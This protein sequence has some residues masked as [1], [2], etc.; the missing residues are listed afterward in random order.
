MGVC[1]CGVPPMRLGVDPL[2]DL[3]TLMLRVQSLVKEQ[4]ACP[5]PRPCH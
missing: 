2:V 1:D 5:P 4:A 3:A